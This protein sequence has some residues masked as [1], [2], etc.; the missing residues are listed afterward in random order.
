MTRRLSM[1]LRV[2][3]GGLDQL[4]WTAR[5]SRHLTQRLAHTVRGGD[6]HIATRRH[7]CTH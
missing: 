2:A 3:R 4:T 5:L 7:A 6:E 1:L